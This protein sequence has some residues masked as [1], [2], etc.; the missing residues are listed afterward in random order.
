MKIKVT[1]AQKPIA[2]VNRL[3]RSA[4]DCRGSLWCAGGQK[5]SV[6]NKGIRHL[7]LGIVFLVK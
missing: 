1:N 4:W 2:A 6:G 3:E 7:A 5:G